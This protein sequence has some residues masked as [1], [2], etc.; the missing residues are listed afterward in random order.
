MRLALRELRA[1][2]DA[3]VRAWAGNNALPGRRPA[4][5]VFLPSL[6]ILPR[7]RLVVLH[8]IAVYWMIWPC[9][10]CWVIGLMLELVTWRCHHHCVGHYVEQA[11]LFCGGGGWYLFARKIFRQR[12]TKSSNL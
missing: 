7:R 5:I 11:N 1:L 8:I 4:T 10:A 2:R 3:A 12:P 6:H 9:R